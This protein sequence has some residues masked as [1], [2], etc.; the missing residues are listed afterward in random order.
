MVNP[1]NSTDDLTPINGLLARRIRAYNIAR[2]G[3]WERYNI[4]LE[5]A[6][7]CLQ[8]DLDFCAKIITES[9]ELRAGAYIEIGGNAGNE[10]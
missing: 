1:E 4:A 5:K 6:D 9:S 10:R 8:R 3:A 7:V 2:K